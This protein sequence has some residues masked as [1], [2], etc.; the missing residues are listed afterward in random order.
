[1]AN[2]MKVSKI[3]QLLGYLGLIPFV[4][5]SIMVWNLSVNTPAEFLFLI[6]CVYSLLVCSFL[7]GTI[8]AFNINLNRSPLDSILLFL[9]PLISSFMLMALF[10]Q[11]LALSMVNVNAIEGIVSIV[12]VSSLLLSYVI[13][14]A[15]EIKLFEHKYYYK[16][17]RLWL[18]LAVIS[19]HVSWLL[20]FITRYF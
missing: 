10:N 4:L 3:V 19:A 15:Y 8:W 2:S 11:A 1:M 13:L 7:T 5:P 9:M 14:Y 6:F 12:L 18:T 17:M 16:K 20:F